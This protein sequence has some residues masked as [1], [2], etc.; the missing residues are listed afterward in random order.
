MEITRTKQ[1]RETKSWRKGTDNKIRGIGIEKK[2]KKYCNRLT[3]YNIIRNKDTKLY[4]KLTKAE[5]P[6]L[7]LCYLLIINLCY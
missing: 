7:L 5:S 1:A 2:M 4:P 6:F 3:T